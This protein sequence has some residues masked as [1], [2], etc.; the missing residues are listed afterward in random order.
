[1]AEIAAPL[2][3]STPL[4]LIESTQKLSLSTSSELTPSNGFHNTGDDNQE[5]QE[6]PRQVEQEGD[7]PQ[8]QQ[9]QDQDLEDP[10]SDNSDINLG[11]T[12]PLEN[13]WSFWY[14]KRPAAGKRTR[15][16]QESY[17]S[18]LREV[19]AF[20]TVEDFWRYYNH[21]VKPSKIENNSNYHFFKKGI[22]PMWED[23]QNCKGGKWVITLKGG[24]KTAADAIWENLILALVGETIDV[25]DEVCGAVFS[26][27]KNGDRIAVWNRNRDEEVAIMSI[28]R[29]LRTII[30]SDINRVQSS[31]QNHE[32]SIKSGASYSNPSR[33]KM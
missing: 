28:G 25:G 7:E 23:A 8:P 12:H 33:Y 22:K 26:K 20:G 24:D 21:L 14:D 32:D 11:V 31:Y 5:T 2:N 1:M 13:E 16:E 10:A 19:G 27:R 18:N 15:G 4:D 17:E 30:G 3:S 9:D 6:G 29:H